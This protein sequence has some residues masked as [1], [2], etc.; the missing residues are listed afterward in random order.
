MLEAD[1]PLSYNGRMKT[2]TPPFL[3]LLALALTMGCSWFA[4]PTAAPATT[5]PILPVTST[6]T[7]APAPTPQA[8]TLDLRPTDQMR[9]V[10]IPG[11]SFQM[12][13]PD[14]TAQPAHSVTLDAFWI[15]QTEVTNSMYRLC[16]EQGSCTPPSDL[17]YYDQG[18]LPVVYVTWTQAR[19]YCDWAGGGTG[20]VHLPSE[21]QWE[22]AA[23]GTDGRAYPW[24]DDWDCSKANAGGTCGSDTFETLAPVGS[25]P[26]GASPF[27]VLDMTGNAWEWVY[28]VHD[29]QYYSAYPT[30]QWPPN[31]TGPTEADYNFHVVRGGAW[32]YNNPLYLLAYVRVRGG[33]ENALPTTGFRCARSISQ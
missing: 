10:Y 13:G 21:A 2:Q 24:G 12:G 19:S 4:L 7:E 27:G 29:A 20:E 9:M 31:P 18:S 14:G 11:G 15:D 28:D 1:G 22:Y 33:T 17:A 26:A 16:V 8:G 6:P 25:F 32:K 5:P 23:R 3:V 30:D